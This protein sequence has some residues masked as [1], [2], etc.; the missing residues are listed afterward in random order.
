M[1]KSLFL[2]LCLLT[3][4]SSIGIAQA[5][6]PRPNFV[7]VLGDDMRFDSYGSTGGPDWFHCPSIDRI[8]KEGVSFTNFFCVY[9]LCVPSRASM[10][11]SLYPHNNGAYNNS[12][13]NNPSLPTIA[14]IMQ[15]A[16]YHTAFIG[17]YHIY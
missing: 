1:K 14:A 7:F 16:G 9:S 12:S 15:S 11:T 6:G 17:N 5:T 2:G 4:I 8:A 3:L 13:K 10:I